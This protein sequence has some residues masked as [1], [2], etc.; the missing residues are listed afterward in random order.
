MKKYIS[1]LFTQIVKRIIFYGIYIV[2][3]AALPYIIKE[4]I[5][6]D[7]SNGNGVAHAA[8]FIALFVGCIVIGMM[9]QYITQHTAWKV[10]CHFK[11]L[12]RK[13]LFRAVICKTPQ[14]F[15]KK[16]MGEYTSILDRDV[17]AWNEYLNYFLDA[18]EAVIGLI[19]YA[20]FI[21]SLDIRVAV[22]IYFFSGLTL[23]L[24]KLTGKK[25]AE[26]K[27][28]LLNKNGRYINKV[29]DLLQGYG[30]INKDTW[31][32]VAARHDKESG[33]L[34]AARLSFGTYKTF[35]NVL[36][37]SV[38]YLIDISAFAIL[39]I[40]LAFSKI[41][42]GVATATITYIREFSHPLR[43]VV[44]NINAIKSVSGVKDKLL[45]EIVNGYQRGE[46][47]ASF[48]EICYQDVSV[49]YK[50]FSVEHFS[51]RF[52]RGK[53]YALIG[54]N[55]SGK[56]T[57]LKLL[58]GYVIPESGSIQVDERELSQIDVTSF[59]SYIEQDNHVY[60][61]NLKDNVTMFESYAA[62]NFEKLLQ[63]PNV[64]L[65]M[66]EDLTNGGRV[67]QMNSS[68][69]E[70]GIKLMEKED[71]SRLSGGEKQILILI[72]SLLSGRDVLV[73]D[74]PFSAVDAQT[75]QRLMEWLLS[76]DKTIIM[77][78][79]NVRLDFLQKF[80]AV[81]H[82]NDGKIIEK[83]VKSASNLPMEGR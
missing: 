26:K 11:E 37:G 72:R 83:M 32:Q 75:E 25:L 35:T 33:S 40:L 41:T 69:E 22:V 58:M 64:P 30:S 39:V 80:D 7:Y 28:S 44:D 1:K 70:M 9:A 81:L 71:C 65:F 6:R 19:V 21:F 10:D 27:N 67:N 38:M 17:E 51:Y 60:E 79:H 54:G 45:A 2:S 50:N 74:E 24:P 23:F 49:R 59:V 31:K 29:N 63:E 55:G 47:V 3:I 61:E 46:Y 57:I 53:K 82:L 34:E 8:G 66:K 36:N 14:E 15:G 18:L 13:D 42:A 20:I 77:V 43:M 56:S 76:L 4:M 48:H 68:I 78:T 73:L 62:S 16:S 5:D 12:V 52:V